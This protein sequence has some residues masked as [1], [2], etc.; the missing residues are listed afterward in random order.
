MEWFLC[1]VEHLLS[2]EAPLRMPPQLSLHSLTNSGTKPGD[3]VDTSIE[4]HN[5]PEFLYKKVIVID[6]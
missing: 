1:E 3:V 4:K 2:R 5:K 6:F